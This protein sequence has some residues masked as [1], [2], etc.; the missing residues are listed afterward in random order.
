MKRLMPLLLITLL[1][2]QVAFAAW[3]NPFS[4]SIF[5]WIF[6]TKP[7]AVI[8]ILEIDEAATSTESVPI[9]TTLKSDTK[10][11]S[12]EKSVVKPADY[13]NSF[14]DFIFMPTTLKSTGK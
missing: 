2:P 6:E 3:W 5:S 1:L 8:Q 7:A 11:D 4:W 12:I 10:K 13:R 14:W 9:T